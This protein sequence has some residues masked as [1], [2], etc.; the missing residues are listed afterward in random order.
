MSKKIASKDTSFTNFIT[1][2]FKTGYYTHLPACGDLKEAFFISLLYKGEKAYFTNSPELAPYSPVLGI[3]EFRE[4]QLDK[5]DLLSF[6]GTSPVNVF[7]KFYHAFLRNQKNAMSYRNN[8]SYITLVNI[9]HEGTL[10]FD[11]TEEWAY[12]LF[13]MDVPAPKTEELPHVIRRNTVK[14][15]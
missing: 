15:G 5:S 9:S 11:I 2:T 12:R 14:P 4:L 8:T 6:E 10:F 13:K 7:A 1:N 3:S